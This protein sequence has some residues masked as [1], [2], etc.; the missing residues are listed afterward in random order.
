[1]SPELLVSAV[2]GVS[3]AAAAATLVLLLPRCLR[4]RLLAL[5]QPMQRPPIHNAHHAHRK[6]T[7]HTTPRPPQ[8]R[9]LHGCFFLL[10]MGLMAPITAILQT[11]D[12]LNIFFAD[13]YPSR[14]LYTGY[15]TANLLALV[16]L[17]KFGE[18]LWPN[19]RGRLLA[20]YSLYTV[21]LVTLP[22]VRCCAAALRSACM[23]WRVPASRLG[24]MPWHC[25]ATTHLFAPA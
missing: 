23:C 2:V 13:F 15:N 16:V 20:G 22:L 8:V 5:Q 4:S 1:M 11:M 24:S 18:A 10:G 12:Y 19:K 25:G 6:H 9:V 17:F 14:T 3:A 21:I 7:P